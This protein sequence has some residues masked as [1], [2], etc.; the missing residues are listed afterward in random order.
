MNAARRPRGFGRGILSAWLHRARALMA[1]PAAQRQHAR[2]HRGL[3]LHAQRAREIG[4]LV[5]RL[6]A[7]SRQVAPRVAH[8]GAVELTDAVVRE[9]GPGADGLGARLVA[10]EAQRELQRPALAPVAIV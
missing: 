2:E 10:Q 3:L 8:V 6:A 1:A 7:M 9:P 5:R 4:D